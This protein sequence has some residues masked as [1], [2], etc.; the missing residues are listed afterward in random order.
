MAEK[1]RAIQGGVSYYKSIPPESRGK[2]VI[3]A[4]R[5]AKTNKISQ[6]FR[7]SEDEVALRKTYY[8][9]ET[10]PGKK[11]TSLEIA[12]FLLAHFDIWKMLPKKL[13][14]HLKHDDD[15]EELP[16]VER[17]QMLQFLDGDLSKDEK[18]NVMM[19]EILKD[20]AKEKV[21]LYELRSAEEINVEL[22][23]LLLGTIKGWNDLDPM[24]QMLLEHETIAFITE[25]HPE[26]DEIKKSKMEDRGDIPYKIREVMEKKITSKIEQLLDEMNEEET[27]GEA[28]TLASIIPLR[29]KTALAALAQLIKPDITV[30]PEPEPI[31]GLKTIPIEAKLLSTMELL[32]MVEDQIRAEGREPPPRILIPET[33]RPPKPGTPNDKK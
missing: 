17:D 4:Q 12:S 33:V 6:T 29:D 27:N 2:T 3:P 19:R 31:V 25:K 30:E 5:E 20:G 21:P 14:E 1:L 32:D 9:F 24:K 28:T 8:Y 22:A 10:I 11:R 7:L 13:K 18:G 26:I 16:F 23:R 15:P